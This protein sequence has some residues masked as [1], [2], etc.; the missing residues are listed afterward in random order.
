M[1][2]VSKALD[3]EKALF[4]FDC[5]R[6]QYCPSNN[7]W[8]QTG[9]GGARAVKRLVHG[10]LQSRRKTDWRRKG[11]LKAAMGKSIQKA[12]A[13][14]RVFHIWHLAGAPPALIRGLIRIESKPH[15]NRME[16]LR[17]R[18]SLL[19]KFQ[20]RA[21]RTHKTEIATLIASTERQIRATEDTGKNRR[22]P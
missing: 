8:L 10:G 13:Q 14:K 1:E 4:V 19:K 5:L 6:Q 20:A 22:K 9:K 11:P 7:K 17:A 18:L 12:A 16:K 3:R 15:L 21:A 2:M